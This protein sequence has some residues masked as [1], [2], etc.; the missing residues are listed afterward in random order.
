V[1]RLRQS[2]SRHLRSEIGQ[3]LILVALALPLF[4]SV[5]A[6]VVDGSNLMA[7]KRSIQNAA[8][9]AALAASQEL[10]VDGSVCDGPDAAPPKCLYNVRHAAEL[11]SSKNGGA[12]SIPACASSSSTNCY[13]TPYK[14]SSGLIEIR[15]TNSVAGFFTSVVGLGNLFDVSARAVGSSNALTNVTV[16]PG[17]TTD[18][19][20]DPNIIITGGSHTTTDPDTISGGV[21]GAQAFEMSSACA[22]ISYSGAGGGTLGAFATNGGLTFSGAPGK[23]VDALGFDEQACPL[24]S[25][26]GDPTACSSSSA[27]CVKNLVPLHDKIPLNWPVPPPPIPTPVSSNPVYPSQCTALAPSSASYAVTDRQR[28]ASGLATLT[29]NSLTN[30]GHTLAAGDRVSISGVTPSSFNAGGVIITA[31][32]TKTISYQQS[33]SL[34]VV[35]SDNRY[36]GGGTVAFQWVLIGSS[37]WTTGTGGTHAPGVYCVTGTSATLILSNPGTAL[38]AG[39]GYS[40]F[41]PFFDISGGTYNYYYP[42]SLGPRPTTRPSSGYDPQTLFYA[43]GANGFFSN[44]TVNVGDITI[45]GSGA[46][47]TGD[48]FAPKPDV[49]PPTPTTVGGTVF[50]AGGSV[51]AGSGFIEAWRLVIQGNTGSY[52][53][54]GPTVGGTVNPGATH[55]TTDP[56]TTVTGATYPGTTDPGSTNT[57]IVG[58]THGLDE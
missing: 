29:L 6:L 13:Q 51:S 35:P 45:H 40:F 4:F 7:H 31:V 23:K 17:T 21:I 5:V 39:D 57:V 56:D 1:P 49:F 24:G 41:A 16:I 9:A 46:S 53:G 30:G 19:S 52:N 47:L 26:S 28:N 44:G 25:P 32:G 42:S 2:T 48:I 8:D 37:G 58:T 34:G 11:Y 22:A 50:V 36:N 10:P 3:A 55:T 12:S 18:G 15:L 27:P 33:S 54:T 38:T 14:G 43:S 20:T